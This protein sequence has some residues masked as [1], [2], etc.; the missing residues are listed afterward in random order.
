MLRFERQLTDNGYLVLK[1]FLQISRKEQKKRL[2]ALA[3][4]PDTAWRVSENDRWQN[5]HYEECK[6]VFDDYLQATNLREPWYIIDAKEK[7]W[8][9]GA[10][11][12]T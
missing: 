8:C 12:G 2:D 7:K 11:A 3:D 5:R 1:L 6:E 9:R 4:N 10:D